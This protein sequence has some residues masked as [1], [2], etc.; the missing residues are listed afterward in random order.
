[1]VYLTSLWLPIL[2]SAVGVFIISSLTHMVLKLHKNDYTEL[3]NDGAL[4]EA[5]RNAGV[6]PG[7]YA[8]PC[9]ADAKDMG[10][11]E[12]LEK[13]NQGP[14]G[15]MNVMPSG[16]PAMGKYLAL[17]FVYTLIVS[18]FVAYLTGR[19]L[20]AG[21]DYLAVFRV[22]GATAFLAYGVANLVDSVW[23]AQNWGTTFRHIFDGLLYSLV[24][25]GFFGWLWPS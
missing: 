5:M 3:P 20:A 12:M 6:K 11:P 14:V 10:S 24:T 15:F 7:N 2:L 23:K 16:P 19:T 1:M 21:T 17:W 4:R 25:A 22:A 9:P 8:F 13:Y 18:L